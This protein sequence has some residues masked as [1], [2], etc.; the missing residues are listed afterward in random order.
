MPGSA[1]R[2]TDVPGPRHVDVPLGVR[3]T[4]C[5]RYLFASAGARRG[6]TGRWRHRSCEGAP[7]PSDAE[8]AELAAVLMQQHPWPR[9]RALL[10]Q[11]ADVEEQLSESRGDH[12]AGHFPRQPGPPTV[13]GLD[14]VVSKREAH[15]LEGRE[16]LRA[17]IE[18]E[19]TW[20]ADK[21]A[22]EWADGQ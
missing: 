21:L 7:R 10:S 18:W 2:P 14:P 5:Y 13:E 1:G 19:R 20:K 9:A 8:F 15:L 3:C 12:P 6:V 11:L 17:A 16:A 22:A 4:K